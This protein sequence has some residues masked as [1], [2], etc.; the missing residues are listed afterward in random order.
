[1]KVKFPL[2]IEQENCY[3]LITEDIDS[4]INNIVSEEDNIEGK[5]HFIQGK[6]GVGKTEFAK[7]LIEYCWNKGGIS[8]GCAA[9]ALAAT[10]YLNMILKQHIVYLKYLLIQIMIKMKMN[11]IVN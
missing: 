1:L 7:K 10:I 3:K 8:L 6:A 11:L 5:F 4:V 2:T 9:T